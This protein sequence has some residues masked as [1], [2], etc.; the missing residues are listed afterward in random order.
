M[1]QSSSYTLLNEESAYTTE[2]KRSS[3]SKGDVRTSTQMLPE[4]KESLAG[5]MDKWDVYTCIE[6]TDTL[7]PK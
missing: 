5:C 2:K 3:R 4:A 7:R 1:Q 6:G